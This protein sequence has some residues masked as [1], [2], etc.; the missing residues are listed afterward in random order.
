MATQTI[1]VITCYI[2]FIVLFSVIAAFLL[3]QIKRAEKIARPFLFSLCIYFLFLTFANTFQMFKYIEVYAIGE[4]YVYDQKVSSLMLTFFAA[5]APLLLIFQVEKKFVVNIKIFSKYHVFFII[6]VISYI[7]IVITAIIMGINDPTSLINV[8]VTTFGAYVL[9]LHI[10][11]LVFVIATF[12]FLGLRSTGKYRLYA[13]TIAIG[14]SINQILNAFHQFLPGQFLNDITTI[15]IFIGK[16]IGMIVTASG[17]Y[18][19]YSLQKK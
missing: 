1:L 12:G 16:Y 2:I 9:P 4:L 8:G 6:N 13:F 15:L 3:V 17:F 18:L 10:A 19:L 5:A 7:L 11:V 14:W